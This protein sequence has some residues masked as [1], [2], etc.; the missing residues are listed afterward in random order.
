MKQFLFWIAALFILVSCNEDAERDAFTNTTIETPEILNTV[1][2]IP[3]A[4]SRAYI[5]HKRYIHWSAGDEISYFPGVMSNMQYRLKDEEG[6]ANGSFEKITTSPA[7]GTP[8]NYSYA[9]Y[10]Y[11]EGILISENETLVLEL[12]SVQ[13][14]AENSFGVGANTMVAVAE[15]EENPTL[16]FKNAC[17][18]LK[19]QLYGAGVDVR[20]ITLKGNDNEKIAGSV[21]IEAIYKNAP[22]VKMDEN[23]SSTIVLDCQTGV[24]LND[25]ASAPTT[26]WLVIPEMTFEKGFTVTVTDTKGYIFEKS[27]SNKIAIKRNCIQP[28]KPVEVVCENPVPTNQ[29]W[30]TA[31]SQI[32]LNRTD[33]FGVSIS[34]HKF[35]AETGKGIITFSGVL[36]KIGN[37]AFAECYSLTGIEIPN[38]VTEVGMRAFSSCSLL[39]H[40]LMSNG[41]VV[42]GESAF[43]S[44]NHLTK[45]TL[46]DTITRIGRF[47]FAACSGLTSVTI[48]DKVMTIDR[49]AF[50]RC[51]GLINIYCKPTL[52]PS[53]YYTAMRVNDEEVR[54]GVFP[55]NAEM[56]IYVPR[57]A[58]DLYVQ[59]SSY[60][61]NNIDQTNWSVYKPYV[62]PYTF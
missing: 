29:I 24:T 36:T 35:D 22:I 14:Y 60:S 45:I 12:P 6:A 40:V 53:L 11:A 56:K 20:K 15:R 30:Y 2:E 13:Q 17:G 19:L 51:T 58:Y 41:V 38:S 54:W 42:I 48:P 26:F 1:L 4:E 23:A 7:S 37:E 28:M 21:Q 55:F 18:Y 62:E 25:D 50:N 57:N 43:E 32:S 34:R 3:D 59:Y 33:T 27:T 16:A 31:K 39:S 52:P 61:N 44:C 46:P 9:V 5:D 49:E 10:P 47:A 8:L